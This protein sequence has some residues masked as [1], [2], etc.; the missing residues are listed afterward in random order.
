MFNYRV[1]VTLVVYFTVYGTAAPVVD[2]G[3]DKG[4]EGLAT[5]VA[6]DTQ[7]AHPPKGDHEEEALTP[8]QQGRL[9]RFNGDFFQ[10]YGATNQLEGNL[11]AIAGNQLAFRG[12]LIEML[13]QEHSLR[14]LGDY[15]GEVQGSREKDA[16]KATGRE[17]ELEEEEAKIVGDL[18]DLVIQ[19]AG[20]EHEQAQQKA[21]QFNLETRQY[22]LEKEESQMKAEQAVT[23]LELGDLEE[24]QIRLEN[25]GRKSMNRLVEIEMERENLEKQ[26]VA[27]APV[28]APAE[29][30]APTAAAPVVPV[31]SS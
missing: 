9:A 26:P 4:D 5:D 2:D 10:L 21:K 19:S 22:R 17:K 24:Q 12:N 1:L 28:A 27:P 14:E 16:A 15:L 29:T 25:K 20:K 7:D 11:D 3:R 18:K 31:T 30:P 23:A 13:G 8:S 6:P